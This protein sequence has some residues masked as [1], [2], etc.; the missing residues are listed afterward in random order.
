MTTNDQAE[1][2]AKTQSADAHEPGWIDPAGDD[3]A[4]A[5]IDA[6]A[7]SRYRS[8]RGQLIGSLVKVCALLGQRDAV[9]NG[10]STYPGR[11]WPGRTDAVKASR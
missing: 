10:C 5:R 7:P 2:A 4:Q 11:P 1:G 9:A 8:L 3:A 6:D